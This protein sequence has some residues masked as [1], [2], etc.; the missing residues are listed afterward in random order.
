MSRSRVAVCLSTV[1]VTVLVPGVAGAQQPASPATITAIGTATIKP[2]PVNRRS[3]E[4]IRR[5]VRDAQADVVPRALADARTRAQRLAAA[6]NL[7]LGPL[8]S[9]SDVPPSPFG[10]FGPFGEGGTF[11]PGRFCGTVPRF[12]TRRLANGRIR[13][14]RVGTRRLCRTPSQVVGTVSLTYAVSSAT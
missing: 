4:S 1:A 2:E 13:R 11:G 12:R 6:A 14:V 5:A 8:Q 3:N 10:P 7:T 9:V